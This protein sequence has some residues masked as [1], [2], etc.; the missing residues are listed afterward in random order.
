MKRYSGLILAPG[1]EYIGFIAKIADVEIE[2]IQ[3]EIN[4]STERLKKWQEIRNSPHIGV[5][6]R[7]DDGEYWA[8]D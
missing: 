1:S 4:E 6:K 5:C 3:N 7:G 8:A 2:R